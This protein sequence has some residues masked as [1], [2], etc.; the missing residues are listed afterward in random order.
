[1]RTVYIHTTPDGKKY[2]GATHMNPNKRFDKGRRYKY[3]FFYQAILKF[4][5][6]NITHQLYEVDTEEEMKYLEKYLISYYDTTNPEKGY[7]IAKGD[8]TQDQGRDHPEYGKSDKSPRRKEISRKYNTS[9]KGKESLKRAR[10]RYNTSEKGKE[11]I[12]RYYNSEKGKESIKLASKKYYN[13]EKGKETFKRYR[14]SEKGKEIQKNYEASER[15]KEAR[16]RAHQRWLN[17]DKGKNT[18]K[19]YES[20]EKGKEIRKRA[21]QRYREK[22]KKQTQNE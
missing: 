2:V 16:K 15:G 14:M 6:E 1:M 7:N 9:E 3:Q 21:A 4:G 22:K 11:S 12:K 8:S 18:I 13:S 10:Q 17:S 19:Q 20:S 5:W